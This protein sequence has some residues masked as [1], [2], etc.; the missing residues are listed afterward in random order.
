[1]KSAE[2]QC[3]VMKQRTL[4]AELVSYLIAGVLTT[5]INFAVYYTLICIGIDYKI[6]NT[7]AFIAAV[8]FA[9][10]SNKKYVFRSN[11]GFLGEFVKFMIG[12]GLTYLLDIGTMI[13][14]VE[15]IGVSEYYAKIW[16]GILVVAANYLIGKF[17]TFR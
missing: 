12:R 2:E 16:T 5:I 9:Y 15:A 11:N 13:I 1:M 4:S 17:W 10:F 14:Q 3:E 8:L 6:A 7:V